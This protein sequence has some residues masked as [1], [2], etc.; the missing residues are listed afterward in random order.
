MVKN[1]KLLDK[2]RQNP[3]DWRIQEIKTI[4]KRYGINVRQG[5]GSHVV[6]EHPSWIELLTIP[7]H[8][9]IKPIYVKKLIKLIEDMRQA[10]NEPS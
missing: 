4:A 7:A 8:R 3:R 9:P 2:M 5:K 1:N 6:L 10:E